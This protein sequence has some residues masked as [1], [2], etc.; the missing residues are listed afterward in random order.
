M[1]NRQPRRCACGGAC[2]GKRCRDCVTAEAEAKRKAKRY[3][4][5]SDY[6]R[7]PGC[8]KGAN[9]LASGLCVV[10]AN[11]GYNPDLYQLTE[12]PHCGHR[13][14][15]QC[16]GLCFRCYVDAAIRALYDPQTRHK[17]ASPWRLA[18]NNRIPPLAFQPTD[19]QPGSW[20]KVAV[21]IER[22]ASGQQP[23]HPE[24]ATWRNQD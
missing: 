11:D 23:F 19:A 6:G 24:D 20:E 10:C 16:R 7:C 12:C 21:M 22:V 8:K 4:P 17:P 15:I 5:A 3:L 2:V 13:R 14:R 18:A 1:K 9:L